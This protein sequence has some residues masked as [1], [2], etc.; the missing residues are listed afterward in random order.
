MKEKQHA[1]VV[2]C[3][4]EHFDDIVEAIA[5]GHRYAATTI[6]A[7][8]GWVDIISDCRRGAA[9]TVHHADEENQRE[10][11][12]LCEAIEKALPEWEDVKEEY[13]AEEEEEADNCFGPSFS[14]FSSWNDYWRYI[15]REELED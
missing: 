3:V 6:D 12:R 5:D 14:S 10:C 4:N 13:E 1:F 11:P 9:V 15:F 8:D 7:A 2:E